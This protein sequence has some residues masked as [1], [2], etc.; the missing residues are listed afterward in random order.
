[1]QMMQ[2]NE[3]A[4]LFQNPTADFFRKTGIGFASGSYDK[5]MY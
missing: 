5:F 2:L 4:L 1:M 3:N